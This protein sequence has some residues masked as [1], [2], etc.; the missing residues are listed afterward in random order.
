[1][2]SELTRILV[3]SVFLRWCSSLDLTLLELLT[4]IMNWIYYNWVFHILLYFSLSFNSPFLITLGAIVTSKVASNQLVLTEGD[5]ATTKQLTFVST[6]QKTSVT[7]KNNSVL[8]FGNIGQYLD[9][10]LKL[11]T[12]TTWIS[13]RKFSIWKVYILGVK[14][15]VSNNSF[16]EFY[17]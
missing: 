8:K 10:K 12:P 6:D 11:R 1:M 17:N 15:F 14:K 4:S 16:I 3:Y 9:P 2:F 13:G 5:L 7:L